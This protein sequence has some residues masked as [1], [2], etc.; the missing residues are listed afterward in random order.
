M[1]QHPD[2]QKARQMRILFV[3]AVFA[4]SVFDA[5]QAEAGI[6]Y[7]MDF[8]IDGQGATHTGPSSSQFA[9]GSAVGSNWGLS[10]P[11]VDTDTTLNEFV[12]D[13]GLIRVQ[14]WGGSGTVTSDTI[15][16]LS[17]GT[18]HIASVATTIGDDVFNASG[19]GVTWFYAI[20][21]GTPTSQLVD[22]ASL[23]GGAVGSGVS[24]GATFSNVAV[25]SG[26]TLE[27]GFT[28]FVNGAGDGLTVSQF[29]V[30]FTAT[31][32]EPSSFALC[33]IALVCIA[34]R[35]RR[36]KTGGMKN[37]SI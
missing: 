11:D 37:A 33:G 2:S 9:A 31:V 3:S 24:V 15:A 19:E 27:V 29:G 14:D 26:D 30:D 7:A 12:T 8:S 6:I 23:G 35:K 16:I 22:E 13:G 4:L 25:Q 1:F 36:D 32:P 10:W 18:V 34:V 28:A 21:G 17:A 20:N 5:A